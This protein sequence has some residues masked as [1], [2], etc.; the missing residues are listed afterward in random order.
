MRLR[1]KVAIVTGGASG[2]G[3]AVASLFAKEGAT[4]AIGD[5]DLEKATAVASRIHHSGHNARAFRVDVT[6]EQ[7]VQSFVTA[8][9]EA[10]DS[11]DILV[12]C[13]GASPFRAFEETSLEQWRRSIDINL[14]GVFICCKE[15]ASEMV[16]QGS[17]R[18]INMSSVRGRYVLPSG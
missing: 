13:V 7:E 8:V 14:T 9:L 4:V 17:G 6:N 18:I 2:M 3:E 15:V 16:K 1:D 11:I 12:N 10:F 5:I